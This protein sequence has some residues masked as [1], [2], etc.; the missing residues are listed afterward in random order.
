[1]DIAAEVLRVLDEVMSLGGRAQQFRA[2]TPLLGA[3][4]E[5]DSMV[6]VGLINTLEERFGIAVADDEINGDI[7][8]TVGDLTSFVVEKLGA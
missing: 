3:I 8:A 5:F 7:F 2:D 4:P 1:M 6:V